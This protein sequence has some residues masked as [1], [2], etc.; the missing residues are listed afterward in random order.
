MNLCGLFYAKDILVEEQLWYYLTNGW[1]DKRVHAFSNNIS[2]KVK[3]IA[4]LEFELTHYDVAI[5]PA[6]YFTKGTLPII[7]R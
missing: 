7:F 1:R 4:Q 3:A 6:S 2:F 5:Q